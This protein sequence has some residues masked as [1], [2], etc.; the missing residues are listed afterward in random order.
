MGLFYTWYYAGMAVLPGIAG[1]LEDVLGRAAAIEFAA[2]ALGAA[3]AFDVAFRRLV[4][5][6]TARPGP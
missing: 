5:G 6:D 3:L 2:A 4:V 1:W